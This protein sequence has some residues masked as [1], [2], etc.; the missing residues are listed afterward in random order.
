VFSTCFFA[1]YGYLIYLDY[2]NVSEQGHYSELIGEYN[3]ADS[4]DSRDYGIY[5]T[6]LKIATK[7]YSLEEIRS[8][9]SV[10][11]DYEAKLEDG[12]YRIHASIKENT[13]KDKTQGFDETEYTIELEDEDDIKLTSVKTQRVRFCKR[14]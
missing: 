12:K 2:R 1:C 8:D 4:A 9:A 3:C 6:R 13:Q 5:L 14:Q 11:G 7:S 10:V